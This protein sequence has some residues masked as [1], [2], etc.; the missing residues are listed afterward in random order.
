MRHLPWK[1]VSFVA[2]DLETTG[3]YPLEAEICEMAAVK[4]QGGQIVDRFESLIRPHQ[5]MSDFV[6]SIH[7]ITN[8]MAATAPWLEERLPAFHAFIKDSYVI[9]HHAPFDLGFLSADMENAGLP[10][11][12]LP[13]FCTSL[14]G[15]ALFPELE[16]H[17]LVSLVQHFQITMGQAH[18]AL[19]DAEACLQVALRCFEKVGDQ[20]LVNDLIK[21]QGRELRWQNFSI[22]ALKE[23][24]DLAIIINAIKTK[25][26]VE[27]VYSGGSKPGQPRWIQPIGIVRNP[28]GDFVAALQN[29]DGKPKRYMVEKIVSVK[30]Q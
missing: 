22:E 6:I 16:N 30:G 14:M 19:S 5:K 15:Q 4:M 9:A 20:A 11:P 26:E 2:I 1:H 13:A 27:M 18:R 10:L 12:E 7:N 23:K 29:A 8:E 24:R 3:K 25:R 17:R 21:A 28:N